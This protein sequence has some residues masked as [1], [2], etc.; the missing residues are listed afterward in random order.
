MP[1]AAIVEIGGL[2]RWLPLLLIVCDFPNNTSKYNPPQLEQM[3]N[4]E[5]QEAREKEGKFNQQMYTK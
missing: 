4:N 2:S 3:L 1:W 5:A